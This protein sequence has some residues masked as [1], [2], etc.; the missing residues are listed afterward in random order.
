MLV[1]V[2][3]TMVASRTW[4]FSL[5][6]HFLATYMTLARFMHHSFMWVRHTGVYCLCMR[7]QKDNL[8]C[9]SSN[10]VHPGF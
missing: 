6:S 10:P 8:Q 5:S 9:L 3:S 2:E 4:R 7:V 1:C